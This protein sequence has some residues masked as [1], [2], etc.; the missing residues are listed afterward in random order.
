MIKS[1]ISDFSRVILFPKNLTYSGGLNA[2]HK[3]LNK[4]KNYN[5]FDYFYLND[6][7]LSFYKKIKRKVNIYIF[8]TGTIQNEPKLQKKLSPIFK[9]ITTVQDISFQKNNPEAYLALANMFGIKE[10]ETVFVDDKY[11]NIRAAGTTNVKVIQY[12]SA[13]QTIKKIEELLNS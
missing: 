2:L 5:I 11:E 8:T 12:K 4:Q 13:G 1:I 10:E 6:E 7:L 3:K 9:K